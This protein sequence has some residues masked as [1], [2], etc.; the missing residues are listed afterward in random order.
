MPSEAGKA[1]RQL[2]NGVV[3]S[4]PYAAAPAVMVA[5]GHMSGS[6]Q[7]PSDKYFEFL[8]RKHDFTLQQRRRAKAFG[9]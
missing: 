9:E 8:Q 4:L 6:I 5:S 3:H 7:V 1:T 2:T